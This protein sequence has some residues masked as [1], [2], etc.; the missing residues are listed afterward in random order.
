MGEEVVMKNH[1]SRNF[2]LPVALLFP[3]VLAVFSCG[4]NTCRDL[5]QKEPD[6]ELA[7]YNRCVFGVDGYGEPVQQLETLF[8]VC[9]FY[10][11]TAP[12]FQ[13][14]TYTEGEI[15]ARKLNARLNEQVCLV[16]VKDTAMEE[17]EGW[18]RIK[19]IFTLFDIYQAKEDAGAAS[20]V[21]AT[22]AAVKE[23]DNLYTLEIVFKTG[24][25]GDRF[26]FFKPFDNET[27]FAP[28]VELRDAKL[29]NPI[30]NTVEL[31]S[32]S[33]GE[34]GPLT[35][36]VLY[37]ILHPGE[38]WR[39]FLRVITTND[40]VKENGLCAVINYTTRKDPEAGTYWTCA[41]PMVIFQ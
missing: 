16:R 37:K 9:D 21:P 30:R 6:R 28:P 5:A 29:G 40:R 1:F 13:V 22:L 39:V 7:V 23:Q 27:P 20:Q 11:N 41:S 14:K 4:S 2:F 18:I 34:S 8:P 32:R 17:R 3:A 36:E 24:A 35:G 31:D 12:L 38:Q 10:V 33:W 19:S 25:K 26:L 15:L